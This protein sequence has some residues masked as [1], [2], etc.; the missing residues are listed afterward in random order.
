MAYKQ[1]VTARR[2]KLYDQSVF[3]I[4]TIVS[5]F[6]ILVLGAVGGFLLLNAYPAFS[7]VDQWQFFTGTVWDPTN[8]IEPLYGMLPL[9]V[10]TLVVSAISALIAIPI[11]LGATIYLSEI[12][13]PRIRKIMKPAVEV[14][15]GIPSVVLGFFALTVFA[16]FVWD[17]FYP[18]WR[19]DDYLNM[20]NGAVFLAIMMVPIMV[21]LSEDAMNSVP[22]SL[23]EA[24]LA[25]GMTRWETTWKVV[26]P[27]ARPGIVAA[28]ML[29]IGRAVG[30][31]MVV[32]MATG[33]APQLTWNPF[34]SGQPITSTIAIEMGEVAANTPH[35]YVLFELG[36]VLFVITF[37]LNYV[38]DWAMRKYSERYQ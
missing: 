38:A 24:S 6:A 19:P 13:H 28:I 3:V 32:V 20:F 12:A 1:R 2:R 23:K 36:L 30:E 4:L 27:A 26:I 33:S 22:R 21:S 14:L 15:A 25:L 8:P 9:L 29:S 34:S 16:K 35:Y 37:A 17:L 7:Q 10:A 11:G 5:T 18:A 31:T